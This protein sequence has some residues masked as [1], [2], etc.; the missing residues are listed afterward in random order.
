MSRSRHSRQPPAR[1]GWSSALVQC[2]S[3]IRIIANS[4]SAGVM[5]PSSI[6]T[7]NAFRE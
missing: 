6:G 5:S 2:V 1:Q 3:M 4:S 7:V